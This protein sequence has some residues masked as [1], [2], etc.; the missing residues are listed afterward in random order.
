MTPNTALGL[1]LAGVAFWLET[2]KQSQGR[3][4]AWQTSF[5]L[6][7]ALV[8]L[9]LGSVNLLEF[10]LHWDTGLGERLFPQWAAQVNPVSRGRLA[11]NTALN[12]I[13]F[14]GSMWLLYRRQYH[15]A[16]VM[17]L[18]MFYIALVG[19]LG[20]LYDVE[21]LYGLGSYS[22]MSLPTSGAFLLLALAVLLRY[23]DRGIVAI[24]KADHAGGALVR[25]LVL[26]VGL[27][28][29]TLCGLILMGQRQGLYSSDFGVVLLCVSVVLMLS[30]VTWWSGQVLEQSDYYV[31][32]DTLTGLPNRRRFEQQLSQ[33]M[34]Y[35]RQHN[36][37]L[38]VLF[39]DIDRFKYINDVLGHDLGDTLLVHIGQRL[40]QLTPQGSLLARW[41]GDE[42][43]L[44]LPR[45]HDLAAGVAMAE[46]ILA[47]LK[48]P[49]QL[50]THN[51]NISASLGVA[52]FPED[53]EDL[54][55]LLQKADL[56]LFEAKSQGRNTYQVYSQ[57]FSERVRATLQL[58]NALIK[59]LEQEEFSLYYQPKISL[60]T[61]QV[62]GL[63]A[64]LRWDSPELGRLSPGHFI[65]IAE[66]TGL[67]VTMGAWV[68]RE[69]CRQSQVWRRAG[70]LSVPIAV[71]LSVLQ[72]YQ[73]DL[74]AQLE[75]LL[76]TFDL[77]P[78][79]LE[80]EI[81]ETAAM[82][83]VDYAQ[84]RLHQLTDLGLSLS[85]DDFG[86]GFSSLAYL[87]RFPLKVLK[88]DR[89]FIAPLSTSPTAQAIA[90]SIIELGHGLGMRVLAE[91]VETDDQL[92][93][94]R[95]IGC[96]EVQGYLFQPPMP[97]IQAEE[98]LQRVAQA[99][100]MYEDPL[101]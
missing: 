56:A 1:L 2:D 80:L 67:I 101:S 31:S 74:L 29:I 61:G 95:A 60:A 47:S 79:L 72:L 46:V 35:C 14:S 4:Y 45:I 58:E 48:L 27:V 64:L 52:I 41:G 13:L 26:A 90:R 33:W 100:G 37:L 66:E 9:G 81:T 76:A 92:A 25:R 18:G 24:L 62:T 19:F 97:A 10:F 63:E 84:A 91:G 69:S 51:L 3:R 78:S 59:A 5:S 6:G 71:N 75:Q 54:R 34:G 94:L 17:A 83:D 28:P 96:D 88:I 93:Y 15:R 73:A 22:T 57:V 49:F 82:Q 43:I 86:T 21:P 8:C 16:Q 36:H 68:L 99:Q 65:P 12:F 50:Q 38:C 39:L 87:S 70:L 11:P 89:A 20:Y 40:Q 44:L 77:P 30:L 98:F 23:P 42:F 55:A 85:L 32:F 53:G 7:L